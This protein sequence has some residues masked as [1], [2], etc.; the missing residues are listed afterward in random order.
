M[1]TQENKQEQRVPCST[2]KAWKSQDSPRYIL[3][4][5]ENELGYWPK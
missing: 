4:Q 3:E 5:L 1:Q 2:E